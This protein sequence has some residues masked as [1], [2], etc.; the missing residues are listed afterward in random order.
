MD[1][2]RTPTGLLGL[3]AG[4]LALSGCMAG[5]PELQETREME[6][7]VSAGSELIIDVGAGSLSVEGDSQTGPVRVI[8][9]SWQVSANDDYTLALE[10]HGENGARLEA[11]TGSGFGSGN[12]R[13]DLVVHAPESLR[14]RIDDGSGSMAVR[15]LT[16][17]LDIRDGS[18]SIRVESIGGNVTIEDGSGSLRTDNIAGN[19]SID[20]GSRSIGIQGTGGDVHIDDG[21]GSI[22]VQRTAGTVTVSDGSGSIE[23]DGAEDFRLLEDG[24]GSVSTR[25]IRS[26]S[27]GGQ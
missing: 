17:D 7:T 10:R 19:L 9:E 22:T 18:G 25:N 8:A 16:G 21:S 23:V 3:M 13:I 15:S 6:L 14:V 24:S 11:H 26:R 27:A 4:I 2:Y 1:T 20:D 5:T 12:D